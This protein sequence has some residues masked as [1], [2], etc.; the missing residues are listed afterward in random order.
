MRNTKG[1]KTKNCIRCGVKLTSENSY[2]SDTTRHMYYCRSCRNN[3]TA[4]WKLKSHRQLMEMSD[5]DF[6][7][8]LRES[9]FGSDKPVEKDGK[10]KGDSIV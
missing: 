10:M 3:Y 5:E 2:K 9:G 1:S 8:L 7:K 6:I 4:T